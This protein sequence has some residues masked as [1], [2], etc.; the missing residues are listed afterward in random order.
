M[1]FSATTTKKTEDLIAVALKKEPIYIGIEE[2]NAVKKFFFFFFFLLTIL[3]G[4]E[5]VFL[6]ALTFILTGLGRARKVKVKL[7]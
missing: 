1:L 2:K 4:R 6:T 5:N 3:Q 7:L